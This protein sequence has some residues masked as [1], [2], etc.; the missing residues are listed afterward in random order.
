[1]FCARNPYAVRASRWSREL[2]KALER[3]EGD[4]RCRLEW[5]GSAA[6]HCQPT[7][8]SIVKRS[9]NR[10][11][12]GIRHIDRRARAEDTRN[13]FRARMPLE[14]SFLDGQ[15]ECPCFPHT[16][17]VGLYVAEGEPRPRLLKSCEHELHVESSH[18]C[19]STGE[20]VVVAEGVGALPLA[21]GQLCC[22]VPRRLEGVHQGR[23][24][25]VVRVELEALLTRSGPAR[26]PRD[27]GASIARSGVRC[28]S[29][30]SGC[31]SSCRRRAESAG[32]L[33]SSRQPASERCMRGARAA[34]LPPAAPA[35]AERVSGILK[36]RSGCLS[37]SLSEE[38]AS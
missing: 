20:R 6:I 15:R 38:L 37:A 10:R 27:A 14:W 31:G 1:M 30:S 2:S 4:Q 23:L 5:G 29:S 36:R 7:H 24:L 26:G 18:G 34:A 16:A 32:S 35:P 8:M 19:L 28:S 33:S 9:E 3:K 13:V 21:G 11:N 22:R 12:R 17:I 25:K